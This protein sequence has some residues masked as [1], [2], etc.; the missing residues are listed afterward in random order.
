MGRKENKERMEKRKRKQTLTPSMEGC[1][2]IHSITH[3]KV[4][5]LESRVIEVETQ[6]IKYSIRLSTA[7]LIKDSTRIAPMYWA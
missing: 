4:S 1:S 6:E 5:S 2:R 3:R 7:L